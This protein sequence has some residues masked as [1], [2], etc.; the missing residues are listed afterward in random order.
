MK[1][2]FVNHLVCLNHSDKQIRLKL[3]NLTSDNKNECIEGFLYCTDCEIKYPIIEGIAI[4]VKNISEYIQNRTEMYGK[5]LLNCSSTEMK[6]YLKAMGKSI[7]LPTKLVDMKTMEFGICR[8][9]G[10][11][12]ITT[13][14]TD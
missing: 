5:W 12:R 3:N 4:I 6:E 8:I 2:Q 1:V 11:N 7:R 9:N 10:F 14:K 13:R